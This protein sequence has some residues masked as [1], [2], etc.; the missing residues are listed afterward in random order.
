M[1]KTLKA[2]FADNNL[3]NV[4]ESFSPG[5]GTLKWATYSG[6]STSQN[7]DLLFN[8]AHYLA[9]ETSIMVVRVSYNLENKAFNEYYKTLAK[10][11][12]YMGR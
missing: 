12:T 7:N 2:E 6:Y 10:S 3:Q 1:E 8:I 5:A 11:I 9:G 4:K